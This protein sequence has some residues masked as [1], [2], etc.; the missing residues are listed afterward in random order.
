[1]KRKYT[2]GSEDV[3]A[4]ARWKRSLYCEEFT[5]NDMMVSGGLRRLRHDRNRQWPYHRPDDVIVGY[6]GHGEVKRDRFALR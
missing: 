6:V 3:E 4:G 5:M 2:H 1:M